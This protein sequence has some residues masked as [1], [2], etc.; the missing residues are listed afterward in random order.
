[1]CAFNNS[2]NNINRNTLIPN[3]QFR[4]WRNRIEVGGKKEKRIQYK[5]TYIKINISF[6]N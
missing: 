2:N 6:S 5:E 3:S 1:V 4:T